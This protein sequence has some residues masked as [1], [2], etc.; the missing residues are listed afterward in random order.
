M[1][2][3]SIVGHKEARGLLRRAVANDRL[4]AAYLFV[5]PPNVGKTRAA[6]QLAKA[7]NCEQS[8]EGDCCDECDACQ[9]TERGSHANFI[10]VR[11]VTPGQERALAEAEKRLGRA[12]ISHTNSLKL[13]VGL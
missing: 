12:H 1:S 5:G 4:P 2:L 9:R 10:I 11:P 13:W 6:V 3:A 7:I 8:A